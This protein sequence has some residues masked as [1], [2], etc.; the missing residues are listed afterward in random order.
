MTAMIEIWSQYMLLLD[1]WV[2]R[3]DLGRP[4]LD[5]SRVLPA[6]PEEP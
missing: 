5:R 2:P 1:R 4:M 6:F 3:V